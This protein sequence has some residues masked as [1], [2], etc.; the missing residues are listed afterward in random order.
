MNRRPIASRKRSCESPRRSSTGSTRASWRNSFR[1]GGRPRTSSSQFDSGG[2]CSRLGGSSA[3]L[4]TR[5]VLDIR[6]RLV[7]D[8][9]GGSCGEGR[10]FAHCYR[11]S[12]PPST[13]SLMAVAERTGS[14]RCKTSHGRP[15]PFSLS[16]ARPFSLINSSCSKPGG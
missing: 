6:P 7:H 14:I 3:P 10:S 5:L 13:A 11:F 16:R 8:G 15:S 2:A 12:A 4:H 1:P 9:V